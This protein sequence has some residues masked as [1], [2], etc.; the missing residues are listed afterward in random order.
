MWSTLWASYQ[1]LKF[2]DCACA[3]NA[4]NVFFPPP[5]VI[6]PDMYHGTYVTQESWCMPGSLTSGFL[7]SRWWG[8][9]SRHSRRMRNPQFY[10]SG[11]RTMAVVVTVLWPQCVNLQEPC[12]VTR[13][14]KWHDNDKI[15]TVMMTSSNGSFFRVTGPLCGEVIGN[16]WIPL[17]KASDAV[18]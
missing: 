13:Y 2:A 12:I 3:G 6:N 16:E 15:R 18:L 5:R 17:P 4:G 11:K 9:R 1:I 7:W 14:C 8:E 10:V